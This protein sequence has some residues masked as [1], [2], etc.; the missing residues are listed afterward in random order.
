MKAVHKLQEKFKKRASEDLRR[1]WKI[2]TDNAEATCVVKTS[3]VG[4]EKKTGN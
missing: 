4:H 2:L 3:Y 1:V